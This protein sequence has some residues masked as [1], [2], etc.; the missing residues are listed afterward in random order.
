[1]KVVRCVSK[2]HPRRPG[3]TLVELIVVV[4]I[5]AV[6]VGLTASGIFRVITGQRKDNT[7]Q[8]IRKVVSTLNQ[9]VQAVLKDADSQPIPQE[10]VNLAGGNQ[11][12]ARVIWKKLRLKQEFPVT[13][14]EALNPLMRITGSPYYSQALANTVSS[15]YIT[16]LQGQPKPSVMEQSSIC[17]ALALSRKRGG[18]SLNLDDL[19]STVVVDSSVPGLKKI[20]DNWGNPLYF[21]R[22]HIFDEL[23][24]NNPG[25]STLA[26]SQGRDSL[27]PTGLLQ[28]SSWNNAG[29]YQN[30]PMPVH[31]YELLMRDE[32]QPTDPNDLT[33]INNRQIHVGVPN[34]P[35]NP[36][37]PIA[38]YM[39]P[40]VSSAGPDKTYDTDDDI[41]SFR[42]RTGARGD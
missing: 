33:D 31:W 32:T 5:I 35:N 21:R 38:Y 2:R 16:A 40:V 29:N 4:L 26:Q 13:F 1:M 30:N 39:V 6:L 42:L 36:Y 34:D 10:I 12:R 3:F 18:V 25:S 28:D 11:L 15:R 9:Q 17:L 22:V 14:D 8:T 20:V 24:F 7:E 37:T 27:D 41:V 23:K 19:G